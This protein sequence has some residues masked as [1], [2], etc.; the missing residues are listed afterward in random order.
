MSIS[1][2]SAKALPIL[3]VVAGLVVAGTARASVFTVAS[4]GG[5]AV[6]GANVMAQNFSPSV[7]TAP[8]DPTGFTATPSPQPA[9][10]ATVYLTSFQFTDE[11]DFGTAAA[12][13]ATTSLVILAGAFP[14]TANDSTTSGPDVVGV[15]SNTVNTTPTVTAGT[16][17]TWTFNNLSL[18]YGSTYTA[19]LTTISGGAIT[20][21]PVDIQLVH[22]TEDTSGDAENGD[23]F[24]DFNYGGGPAI[25]AASANTDTST[26]NYSAAALYSISGGY[27]QA[28]GDSNAE[29][30]VFT[31]SFL[32]AVPEPASAAMVGLIS[33]VLIGRR[34][35]P[36]L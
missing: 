11:S 34:R 32:T 19:A 4:D 2:F 17:L 26:S 12:G 16:A 23:Y 25:N 13:S 10:G 7:T 28:G 6:N 14:D 22:Y 36:A 20:Y 21:I 29:D 35:G 18:T 8:E 30:T 15:S 24:P 27:F 9:S 5:T 31:A 33:L 1:R 3:P